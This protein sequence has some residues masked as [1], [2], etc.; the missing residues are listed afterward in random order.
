MPGVTIRKPREKLAGA[1][2]ELQRQAQKLGVR[3]LVGA[4]DVRLDVLDAV[5]ELGRDLA[6]PDDGLDRLHLAEERADALERVAAPVLQQPRRLRRDQ[7][8]LRI[9]QAAPAVHVLADLVDDRGGV[10]LLLLGGEAVAAVQDQPAL[11]RAPPPFLRLRHRGDQLRAAPQLED[12]VGRLSVR[13]QFPMPGGMIVGRVQ[14]RAVEELQRFA[15]PQAARNQDKRLQDPPNALV[16]PL[17]H[18]VPP[19]VRSAT[20]EADSAA[21]VPLLAGAGIRPLKTLRVRL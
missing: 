18:P 11:V 13:V 21:P 7:P 14:D 12:A 20:R 10:V 9:A 5:A 2:G 3:L 4:L 1:G 17:G 6:E 15:R 16:P 8:L 19:L